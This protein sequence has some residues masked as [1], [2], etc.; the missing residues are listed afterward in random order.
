MKIIITGSTGFLGRSLIAQ[1][2]KKN[3]DIY[4]ITRKKIKKKKH[5][6]CPLENLKKI[7][8][9]INFIKPDIIMNLAAEVNLKKRTKNMYK[10]N[11][12]LPKIFA[13]YCKKNKKHLI[14][15]ST[16][17][18]NGVHFLYNNKTK[19]RPISH[20]GKSKLNAEI[21]I[22]KIN[23]KYTILRFGG[24]YGNNGPTHLGI[25][26]FIRDAFANKKI[27]FC[28]NPQTLRNYI[29]VN[30]A[31]KIIINC[32]K[33]KILGTFYCGGQKQT[34]QQ[35]LCKIDKIIGKNKKV[36]FLNNGEPRSDQLIENN[37]LI[38]PMSFKK[39][40]EIIKLK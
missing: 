35:M 32:A 9:I 18:I 5:Y 10:V 31:A 23:C 36:M 29:F 19:L 37:K 2:N 28:G 13:E 22:K 30:D 26:K 38:K 21:F 7:K 11:S 33:F 3:N 27:L 17:S 16:T 40:L 20:Y 1:I 6:Y 14:H 8:N 25:N 4:F 12:L 15:I 39:S 24:I 34:F